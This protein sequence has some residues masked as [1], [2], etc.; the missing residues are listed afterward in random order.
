ME[1]KTISISKNGPVT[2]LE[3]NDPSK[4][5][6]MGIRMISE[7][8]EAVKEL[9]ADPSCRA[10][11]VSGRGGRAFSAGADVA[12]L[13]SLSG[14]A[15]GVFVD[16]L[17]EMLVSVEAMAKPFIAAIDGFCLGG[18]L[19]L[20]LACDIRIA[21][22]SSRFAMPEI[23][24]G[25]MPGGGGTYRLPKIIGV[26]N[27]KYMILTGEQIGVDEALKMGLVSKIVDKDKLMA[28]AMSIASAMAQNS[29]NSTMQAKKAIYL[30]LRPDYSAEREAFI[31]S[32]SHHDGQEGTKAFLEKRKPV[33]DGV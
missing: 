28:E 5:N 27:A 11:V 14:E 22:N 24:L 9:E 10:V 23:K 18:G 15:I 13:S 7:F 8:S 30:P 29:P 1:Y 32:L 17:R 26:G 20:A 21:T 25:I 19:E 6:V 16:T 33:F 12:Y 31:S 3:L 2:L 4:L